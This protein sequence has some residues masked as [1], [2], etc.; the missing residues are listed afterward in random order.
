[1]RAHIEQLLLQALKKAQAA[2]DLVDFEAQ[3]AYVE[4]PAD[5][6]NGDYS[7]TIALKSARQAKCAPRHIAELIV[8]YL[9]EDQALEA[10]EIAGPGF[11]N[12]KLKAGAAAS[13]FNKVRKEGKDFARNNLGQGAYTQIEFVSANPVGPMH[14][15]HGRWAAL[16]DSLCRIMEHCSYKIQR[17]FYVNDAGSQMDVFAR[18]VSERYM[19]IVELCAQTQAQAQD[20]GQSK[21]PLE[22]QNQSKAQEAARAFRA[23]QAADL[24][25]SDRENFVSAQAQAPYHQAFMEACGENS[26]GGEYIIRIAQ[27]FYEQD[28]DLW[29]SKD[30]EERELE[31]RERAYAAMM[32][33]IQKTLDLAGVRFDR[34]FSERELHKSDE[35]GATAIT[36]AFDKLQAAS[37]LYEQEGALWFRSSAYGDDKDRVLVK[38]DQSYTYFAADIAYHS[39]KYDRGFDKVIDLWGAD[40]HGYIPRMMAATAA[41]GHEGKLEIVLGQLVNLLRNGEPVRMSKRKGTMISFEELLQEVGKDAARYILVSRSTD[42]EIDFDIELAKKKSADNPVYYVQYAHARICSIIKKALQEKGLF[43]EDEVQALSEEELAYNMKQLSALDRD[44]SSLTDESE[45]EL[46]R[47][48]SS[49]EDLLKSCARDRAPHRLTHYA[50]S[51]AASFH[52]FYQRCHVLTEDEDLSL[53]RLAL[54]DA[55]RINLAL[56]LDLIGVSAPLKM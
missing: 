10:V 13:I 21:D 7:S 31:F 48:I 3:E 6:S 11:I 51:L 19:Q 20:Q 23:K 28:G 16:G 5:S 56:C 34:Y 8:K 33:D 2:G 26:Y 22:A 37:C 30:K 45:L 49:F 50:Q 15:G 43:T 14:M 52:Q 18:S 39:D 29:A 17:E 25:E 40:H 36:R 24:L 35:S 1:M 9:D 47:L 55:V 54:C 44:L 46:A 4:R 38:S 12:F 53:A 32:Q 42:Q 27:N 41:L